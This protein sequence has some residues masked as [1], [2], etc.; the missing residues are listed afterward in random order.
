MSTRLYWSLSVSRSHR[1]S[2]TISLEKSLLVSTIVTVSLYNVTISLQQ[3]TLQW[4]QSVSTS[5]HLSPPASPS[6]SSSL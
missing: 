2:K 3:S 5:L 4:S 1:M 6:V